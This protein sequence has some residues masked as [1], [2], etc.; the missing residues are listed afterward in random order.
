[1]VLFSYCSKDAGFLGL[2][3]RS[4]PPNTSVCFTCT[5]TIASDCPSAKAT[6]VEV[7]VKTAVSEGLILHVAVTSPFRPADRTILRKKHFYQRTKFI[8]L[9]YI[10]VD[11]LMNLLINEDRVGLIY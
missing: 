3:T 8:P 2:I 10:A 6:I 11:Y 5:V 7:V 1:M 9:Q 4:D